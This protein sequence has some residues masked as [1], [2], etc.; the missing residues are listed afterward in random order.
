MVSDKPIIAVIDDEW[1]VRSM[2]A[3]VLRVAGYRVTSFSRGED[4]IA[5]LATRLPACAIVDIYM[6]QMTGL[7]VQSNLLDANI[8]I[9][10][11]LITASDDDAIDDAARRLKV[12]HVLRKP[13][14]TERLLAAVRAELA[15]AEPAA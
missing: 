2:L 5:S 3:R 4:F 1:S 11:I 9:P 8:R 7:E 14:P 6:P 13:F 12:R 10:T 15:G